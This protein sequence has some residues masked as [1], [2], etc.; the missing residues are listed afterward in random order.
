MNN[1][2]QVESCILHH[3][4]EL[5]SAAT[6]KT[7]P[8]PN[9]P[10]LPATLPPPSIFATL[11][12]EFNNSNSHQV[13]NTD[14]S[15]NI[16][17]TVTECA[18]HLELLEAFR[19]LK[20]RV[21]ESNALDNTFGTKQASPQRRTDRAWMEK[22]KEKWHKFQRLAV[23][24][25]E[26]W[27]NKMAEKIGR[28]QLERIEYH[29]PPVDVLMVWHT[30]M[31]N[32]GAYR[33]DFRRRL[34]IQQGEFQLHSSTK[35]PWRAIHAAIDYNTREFTMTER[36]QQEWG[37]ITAMPHN[38]LGFLSDYS[39]M[40]P[41]TLRLLAGS[42]GD[43]A[44]VRELP[45]P[46]YFERFGMNQSEEELIK[47][48]IKGSSG[49]QPS[50][51]LKAAVQRQE[52]FV[53]R[54]GALLWIRSPYLAGT[55]SRAIIRYSRF[56]ELLRL[57]HKSEKSCQEN[58]IPQ[59]TPVPLVPTLDIDIVW[60]TH[61]LDPSGYYACCLERVGK[62]VNHNDA[63]EDSLLGRGWELTKEVYWKKF[64]TVYG[65][66]FCWVCEGV[67]SKSDEVQTGVM[68]GKVDWEKLGREVKEEVEYWRREEIVRRRQGSY[69]SER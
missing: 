17:P 12:F 23:L 26:I 15:R 58:R 11:D 8:K 41:E 59:A 21:L 61:Q 49:P 6:R 7:Q 27:W 42:S 46:E 63:F 5:S 66:C 40:H 57:K 48:Y 25:F 31:L 34:G 22:R 65:G 38:L 44:P 53:E 1:P 62:F 37:K 10:N 14:G 18:V 3:L 33:E 2:F 67:K 69:R 51:D 39:P 16:L 20:Q 43:L 4:D 35:L 45:E 32:P 60:H 29:L 9:I 28:G 47:L 68:G 50:I 36:Q 19:V 54:M 55:L 56:L 13:Q 52:A 64:G 24:R 30:Y